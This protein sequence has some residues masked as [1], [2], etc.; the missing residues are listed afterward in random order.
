[1]TLIG[2][3]IASM[4]GAGVF[5]TSGALLAD[6]PPFWILWLWVV[7]GAIALLGA[8][9]YGGLVRQIT[10]SGGEYLFLSRAVHPLAGFLAGWISLI[11]GFSGALAFTADTLARY[12]NLTELLP[13]AAASTESS[14]AQAVKWLAIAIVLLGAMLHA[15]RVRPGARAQTVLVLM[16][17]VLLVGLVLAGLAAGRDQWSAGWQAAA[18][19]GWSHWL[20]AHDAWPCPDLTV[21]AMGL[22]SISFAYSGFN[23]AVYVA[24]EVDHPQQRIPRAM[25]W[26]TAIVV[27][28]YG[29]LNYIFVALAAPSREADAFL[30][31]SAFGQLV[32]PWAATATRVAIILALITSVSSLSLAGPRVIAQMAVDGYMPRWLAPRADAPPRA[33]I[34]LQA[35]VAIGLLLSP[36]DLLSYTATLLSVSAAGTAAC[37]LL[38]ALRG[39]PGHRPVIAWP[40]PPLLFAIFSLTFVG[41]SLLQLWQDRSVTI[42]QHAQGVAIALAFLAVGGLIYAWYRP[43]AAKAQ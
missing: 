4:I 9:S 18:R 3:V 41:L 21:L 7:G 32:G 24:G 8:V 39:T 19:D 14:A 11:A 37:L 23:A 26:G 2:L 15:V 16:K 38:P 5:R 34:A 17:I 12:S 31:V 1:L 29:L 42:R 6:L 28:L 33:A 22:L 13:G 40:W 36:I 43:R 30:A 10:A 25:R 20:A 35:A 27:V